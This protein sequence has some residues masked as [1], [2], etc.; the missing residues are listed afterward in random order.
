MSQEI[1]NNETFNNIFNCSII[2]WTGL[3]LKQ[4]F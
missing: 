3:G 4:Y 2:F 1:F